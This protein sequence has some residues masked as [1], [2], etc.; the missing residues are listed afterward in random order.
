MP[1]ELKNTFAG[2]IGQKRVVA[3][4]NNPIFDKYVNYM[5]D[6]HVENKYKSNK[7]IIEE[8]CFNINGCA[9]MNTIAEPDHHLF[10]RSTEISDPMVFL[11]R[12]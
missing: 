7:R 3:L 9:K 10:K 6:R 11:I 2:G 12:K 8:D 4:N 1:L 5:A